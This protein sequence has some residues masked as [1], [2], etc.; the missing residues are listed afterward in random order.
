MSTL[1][2]WKMF[3]FL[4]RKLYIYIFYTFLVHIVASFSNISIWIMHE[5]LI[6]YLICWCFTLLFLTLKL[7]F[8]SLFSSLL[9]FSGKWLSGQLERVHIYYIFHFNISKCHTI[10]KVYKYKGTE[11]IYNISLRIF[12]GFVLYPNQWIV[13]GVTWMM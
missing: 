8:F 13:A 11:V 5:W 2:T 1:Y 7:L 6:T 12:V 9:H 10:Y 4:F 3:Q